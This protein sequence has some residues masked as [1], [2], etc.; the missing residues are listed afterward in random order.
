MMRHSKMRHSTFLWF[1]LSLIPILNLYWNWK[2]S[3]LIAEHEEES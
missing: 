3:R 2:C 1:V